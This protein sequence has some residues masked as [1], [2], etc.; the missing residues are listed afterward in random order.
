[1]ST[2]SLFFLSFGEKGEMQTPG[3]PPLLAG[4]EGGGLRTPSPFDTFC[5]QQESQ[6][7]N[8]ENQRHLVATGTL[9]CVYKHMDDRLFVMLEEGNG[10]ISP[11]PGPLTLLTRISVLFS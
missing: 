1:M 2:S 11:Q 9:S 6:K 10:M 5:P 3:S 4:R 7:G 8:T